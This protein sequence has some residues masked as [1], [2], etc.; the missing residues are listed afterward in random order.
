MK[1]DRTYKTF[2]DLK[3]EQTHQSSRIQVTLVM[4]IDM[5]KTA[6]Y[7]RVNRSS[8]TKNKRVSPTMERKKKRKKNKRWH[9]RVQKKRLTT[10]NL[11]SIYQKIAKRIKNKLHL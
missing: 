7:A 5:L 1:C 8:Q 10:A 3:E 6:W 11:L 4:A 2:N 9:K